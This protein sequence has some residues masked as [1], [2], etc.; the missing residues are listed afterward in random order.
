MGH[1]V[2]RRRLFNFAYDSD[3]NFTADTV[4]MY[5]STG[6]NPLVKV[7]QTSADWHLG[8][9]RLVNGPGTEDW[10]FTGVYGPI[11][12]AIRGRRRRNHFS[13][14]PSP[15]AGDP[16][17]GQCGYCGYKHGSRGTSMSGN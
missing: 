9:L 13:Y 12:A 16:T 14:R 17:Q 6:S 8:V 1:P 5:A 4:G 7:V 3:I 15:T 10:Y 2:H 11:N